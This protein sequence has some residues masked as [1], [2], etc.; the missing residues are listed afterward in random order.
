[1]WFQFFLSLR[2]HQ[3]VHTDLTKTK[4]NINTTKWLNAYT[5]DKSTEHTILLHQNQNQLC[6]PSTHVHTYK[7]FDSWRFF[8]ALSVLTIHCVD[9]TAKTL[10]TNDLNKSNI[11]KSS[12]SV[13]CYFSKK[14]NKIFYNTQNGEICKLLGYKSCKERNIEWIY[15][16]WMVIYITCMY[17]CLYTV[18]TLCRIYS[19][20]AWQYSCNKWCSVVLRSVFGASGWLVHVQHRPQF[21]VWTC[22][23]RR[24]HFTKRWRD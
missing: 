12:V 6:L 24:C 19:H 5:F 16:E 22:I 1:M 7:E 4:Q 15:K 9:I 10:M 17:T 14:W 23:W 13:T 11:Y 18:F 8:I 21:R 2:K 3:E 20:K